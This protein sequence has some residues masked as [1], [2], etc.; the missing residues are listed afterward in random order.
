[1][2]GMSASRRFQ[3]RVWLIVIIAAIG[4]VALAALHGPIAQGPSYHRFADRRTVWAVPNLWNVVSNVPFLAVGIVGLLFLRPHEPPGMLPSLRASYR[5]FLASSALVG[6]GSAYYHLAPGDATLV[7]DRLPMAFAFMAFL[8]VI[9]GEHLSPHVGRQALLP[10]L[11]A[12][13]LSVAWWWARDDLRPY[14][15]VQY[16]SM[17]LVPLILV[18]C[19]SRLSHVGFIWG[20]L[21]AYVIAKAFEVLDTPVYRLVGVS[22]H[23]VK[24]IAAAGGMSLLV[25]ALQK[26][27]VREPGDRET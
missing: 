3:W 11:A 23:S 2:H 27:R 15:L 17:A 8:S 18:L 14:I 20:M 22:G 25:V 13:L 9:V 26:R 1:M 21:A 4:T 24:H 16:L 7:W 10:L 19:P 12:G 6:I 5:T